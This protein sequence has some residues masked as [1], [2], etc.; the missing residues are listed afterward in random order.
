MQGVGKRDLWANGPVV[1]PGY[2]YG[3]GW[4]EHQLDYWTP[5]NQ[6]AFYPRPNDQA[7]SNNAMDF[8]PQSKYLLDMSYFR[9]KNITFG[10]T[11]PSELTKKIYIDKFR[12]YF[13]GENLFEFDNLEVPID[14]EVDY[15]VAGLNDSNTFGRVYPFTRSLS[16][17]VQLS[18]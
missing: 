11:I 17:G 12:V 13:S 5:E 18:L 2:R 14:P 16:F 9:M 3:E 6:D 8:L 10:Y 1:I 4:F 15:T 7:Q